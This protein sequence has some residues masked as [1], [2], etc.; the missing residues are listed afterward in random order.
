M[1][2][3][4]FSGS[5]CKHCYKCVRSCEVKAIDIRN[6]QAVIS[7]D[8]C[9]LCG[10]CLNICPQDAKI[11]RSELSLVKELL[12]SGNPVVLTLAPSYRALL[13][14][15]TA[16]QM[17]SGFKQLGFAQVR[18]SAEGSAFVTEEYVRLLQQGQMDNIITSCCP[19]AVSMIE[20]YYPELIP[21]LAPVVSP[22]VAQGM[23]LKH[24][25]GSDTRVVFAGPCI[26][27]KAEADDARHQGYI[28]AVLDFSELL[29]FAGQSGIRFSECEPGS[30]DNDDP[31]INRLYPITGGILTATEETEKSRGLA[32]DSYRHFYVDGIQNCRELCE[33]VRRGELHHCFVEMNMCT[34]SCVKGPM[35]HGRGGS[36]FKL[37]LDY[38]Q[39]V[40]QQPAAPS[41]LISGFAASGTLNLHKK[42]QDRSPAAPIPTQA[43]IREIMS[44]TGKKTPADE[45]NCG[46][47]GYATC[48]E[49]A[50]AEFQGRA[51]KSM[52]MAYM[53]E[54]A[55]SLSNLVMETS[56]NIVIIVNHD[57]QILEY[58]A[59]GEKYFGKTR[60]QA[61]ECSL[62][63]LID[64]SDFLQVL[65]SHENIHGKKVSFPEYHLIVL[66]NIVYLPSQDAALATL[67]DITES[68]LRAKQEHEKKL[69]T[70]NMAQKV[71]E[72]QMMV[73]QEIAGLLGE[74]T[75]ETKVTLSRI[76]RILLDDT[77]IEERTPAPSRPIRDGLRD[78]SPEE[79][80]RKL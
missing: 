2:M 76:G 38:E 16:E 52:C 9:I 75:A 19:S 69:E 43:Q 25:L 57:L 44:R 65:E 79:G 23:L 32:P 48:R 72:K 42:F 31:G 7:E 37:R 10:H 3:I 22:M 46:A 68:E 26:A 77:E 64:P 1:K 40:S 47:C 30:F 28:D 70:V 5:R 67:I 15:Y 66:E 4:D 6:S 60:T 11:L 18:E 34:G 24:L 17:V 71:I 58:S 13:G 29:R 53:H 54:Q 73:A 45:L 27:R 56:P 8:R 80:A 33:S 12:A 78:L 62:S 39:E 41:C 49:K 50:I 59:V 63:D 20:T 55:A 35:L 51:E 61:L 74:T 36:R 21:H 14:N